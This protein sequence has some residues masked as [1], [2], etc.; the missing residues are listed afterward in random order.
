MKGVRQS[1][2]GLSRNLLRIHSH[3][4]A[5][6]RDLGVPYKVIDISGPDWLEVIQSSNCDAFLVRPSGQVTIW[7][8][9]F[10]E[11]LKVMTQNLGK[12]DFFLPTNQS[13]SMKANVACSIGWL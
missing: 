13:G 11:R 5:A 3:Y 12:N 10:D 9:M 4:I 2:W 8:Q 1:A 6:C 7:K